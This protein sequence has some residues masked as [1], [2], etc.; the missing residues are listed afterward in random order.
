M[1]RPDLGSMAEVLS[2]VV[3]VPALAVLAPTHGVLGIAW[4][5]VG[6]SLASLGLLSFTT[7]KL[8]QN[9]P[10]RTVN[11]SQEFAR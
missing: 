9:T 2:W 5:L 11:I 7:W 3:L 4:S 8:F 1:G 10:T 6:A